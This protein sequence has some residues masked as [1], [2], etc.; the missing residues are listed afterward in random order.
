MSYTNK[1]KIYTALNRIYSPYA[2][3]ILPTL[4]LK[5]VH[6]N[7]MNPKT[8]KIFRENAY[9]LITRADKLNSDFLS[10][11]FLSNKV[12]INFYKPSSF[13]ENGFILMWKAAW[14][15]Q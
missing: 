1:N 12:T 10:K 14:L 7:E 8:W 9:K 3:E 13:M 5:L 11:N 4:S 6:A 2:R 15:S